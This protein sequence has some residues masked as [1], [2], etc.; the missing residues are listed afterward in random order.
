ADIGAYNPVGPSVSYE[1]SYRSNLTTAGYASP[2]MGLGWTDNYDISIT[3][4]N[5]ATWGALTLVYGNKATETF[6][7]TLS[8]GTPTGAFSHP[9]GAPYIVSGV[10]SGTTG[11]WTSITLTF[12]DHSQMTFTPADP[13]A[14]NVKYVYTKLTNLV[15]RYVTINRDPLANKN[16]VTT[17][18]NDLGA[19]LLTF[20][21]DP[22]TGLLA[23]VVES[24]SAGD[25]TV[26]YTY[27]ASSLLSNVSQISLVGAATPPNQWKYSPQFVNGKNYLS[28]VDYP[29]PANPANYARAKLF[30]DQN[31]FVA[32]ATD[33]SGRQTSYQPSPN[34]NLTLLNDY[35]A[36][37][38]LA[39][40]HKQNYIP[41]TTGGA[42]NVNSGFLDGF[43]LAETMAYADANNPWMPTLDN[44][45][46]GEQTKI[47]YNDTFGNPATITSPRGNTV[48]SIYD[49]TNFALGQVTSTQETHVTG[50]TTDATKQ[51]T[52]YTYYTSADGA[53]NGL[54]KTIISPA[55][56]ST[57]LAPSLVTTTFTYTLPTATSAG[58]QVLTV[59][60]P[61]NNAGGTLTTTYNYTSDPNYDQFGAA[62]TY[63]QNEVMGQ[64]L[65]VTNPAGNVTHYRYDGRGNVTLS[66]D[67]SGNKTD[68]V[69]NVADQLVQTIAPATNVGTP[70][71][72]AYTQTNYQYPGG[73]AANVQVYDESGA[74]VRQVN[75]T[76]S[77]DGEVLSVTGSTEP[78][79]YTY[80][81]LSRVSTL[82]D[83]NHHL[84]RYSYNAAGSL[85]QI[86]YPGASGIFDTLTFGYDGDQNLTS[87]IDGRGVTTT[88][89][90]V[91]P[92]SQ[93]TS[94]TYSG[95][96]AG[97]TPIGTTSY[98][99]DV[100]GRLSL[101][102]DNTGTTG[103]SS[104]DDL[105]EPLLMTRSFTGGPQNQQIAYAHYP[106]G[107]RK[108]MQTPL[109]TG[110]FSNLVAYQY[111]LA[112][113]LK[114]VQ[115]PWTSG[116]WK[117]SY[118]SNG[119]LSATNGPK[120]TGS[121]ASLGFTSYNYNSR[122]FLRSES[123]TT[124]FKDAFNGDQAQIGPSY[125]GMSYD[126]LGNR[127]GEAVTLPSMTNHTA[128]G[129]AVGILGDASHTL[130]YTYDTANTALSNRDVMTGETSVI[131]GGSSSGFLS[132]YKHA[133]THGF[134]YDVA[135]NP[136]RYDYYNSSTA[137]DLT[138][139]GLGFTS[140]NQHST[141]DFGTTFSF[142]GNGNPTTYKSA[143]FSFD[144]EDRLTAIS[145]PAFAAT[146]DGDGLRATKTAAGVTTYYIYDGDH[147]VIE[148]TWN[149][150]SATVYALN[151]YVADGWRT[152][153]EA[154]SAI[155]YD[156]LYDPQGNLVER[157][158][159]YD[160][161][162]GLPAHDQTI[163]EGYGALRSD[164][165]IV[166]GPGGGSPVPARDPVGFGGQYGY[167]TDRETGLLCLTH[168]YY[169]PGTGRF[170]NRDPIGYDGGVNL[171]GFAGGNPVN[172]ADP[173]GFAPSDAELEKR[174]QAFWDET[175]HFRHKEPE[176]DDGNL[177]NAQLNG[178]GGESSRDY[179][180][181][182][183]MTRQ[184]KEVG[185]LTASILPIPGIAEERLGL[186]AAKALRAVRW[187]KT[188]Q[189]IA[190]IA[191]P[192]LKQYHP[193]ELMCDV[194]AENLQSA[195]AA[196]GIKSEIIKF[197]DPV[198]DYKYFKNSGEAF[199]Q[200][201]YHEAVRV[202]NRV[203]DSM[204]GA[205]GMAMN[206]WLR[207]TGYRSSMRA[208]F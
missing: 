169:D 1:R 3:S 136:T 138:F 89:N 200:S 107:S 121:T 190:E 133:W 179:A 188:N 119:W 104:Y 77:V 76:Y 114:Q 147:P 189:I 128:G 94:I 140:D 30:Y 171:Y 192:I 139:S 187:R 132:K 63:S 92:E 185:I 2:G 111:D 21:Y 144:P 195:F 96:P 56:D 75:T 151:G 60:T 122:G 81:G 98:S 145:S 167:Y 41:T 40:T 201:G 156:Y 191:G 71:A 91:D 160:Y 50:V 9:A 149:G 37:G 16:R 177:T 148:E 117:H 157:Q 87:K 164:T 116:L 5:A 6:A 106:D 172:N 194:V 27:Y 113:R 203:Y 186:A 53:L 52:T 134:G 182:R 174:R 204:T 124:A 163:Y 181:G 150:T 62:G 112:G 108:Q 110:L 11:Q 79:T 90:R 22:G 208:R 24:N 48:T 12:K 196:K 198:N 202:G 55:P 95:L 17:V 42:K 44:N 120:A 143:G 184:V 99:F 58:G 193:S 84:T 13:A 101:M 29:N 165:A 70:L 123:I 19:T 197:R 137:T 173:S 15:G 20:S 158:S 61:G 178:A 32:L 72:R 10:P 85:A 34:T 8:G 115:F 66:I 80:D 45:R 97:V 142:D 83:G 57:V 36:N 159:E 166:N 152:R 102:T 162:Q 155:A 51:A 153:Y 78:V 141:G 7:P 39:M 49:F 131:S 146:Y 93:V 100:Y 206:D 4:A 33:A 31:G 25:R 68:Y 129:L 59:S 126:A 180:R 118:L 154:V 82:E 54:V 26:S 109:T 170:V 161:N 105:D 176:D 168:R 64:P 14:T 43:G 199:T 88:Y 47:A 125:A 73:L 207:A 205:G 35:N 183:M 46:K 28:A 86:Q 23:S 67:A 69:Y 74:L 130:T 135:Y 127:L 38:T 65:T 18:Q 103:Y 175:G